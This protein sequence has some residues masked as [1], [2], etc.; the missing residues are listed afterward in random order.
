[1]GFCACKPG[2]VNLIC[3]VVHLFSFPVH[4]YLHV[5]LH[6][7]EKKSILLLYNVIVPSF[8]HICK[9]LGDVLEV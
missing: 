2:I 7:N 4:S 5:N 3:T 6:K 8:I 9:V 1:M